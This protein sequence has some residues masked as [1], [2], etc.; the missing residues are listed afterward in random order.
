MLSHP[1]AQLFS[2]L[3]KNIKFYYFSLYFLKTILSLTFTTYIKT[4]ALKYF[5]QQPPVR[6]TFSLSTQDNLHMCIYVCMYT[7]AYLLIYVFTYKY[8]DICLL[9]YIYICMVL[10]I[11]SYIMYTSERKVSHTNIHLQS[12]THI[13]FPFLL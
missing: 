1:G 4:S 9:I 2:I 13:F 8:L 12:A 6:N 10:K 3:S 5:L 7:Y 11:C